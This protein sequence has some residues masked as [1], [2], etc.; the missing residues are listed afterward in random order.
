MKK[1]IILLIVIA[2]TSVKVISQNEKAA[3]FPYLIMTKPSK[4]SHWGY[5][6]MELA[7]WG[8]MDAKGKTIIKPK[9]SYATEFSEGIAIVQLL[10]RKETESSYKVYTKWGVINQKGELII[11]TIFG[12]INAFS[13]GLAKASLPKLSIFHKDYEKL[14]TQIR[15]GYIDSLGDF[16]IPWELDDFKFNMA[17][18]FSEG[19]ARVAPAITLKEAKEIIKDKKLLETFSG[20]F[21]NDENQKVHSSDNPYGFINMK[22]ELVVENKFAYVGDFHEGLAFAKL[23]GDT[24]FGF[25]DKTGNFI[26]Q[27]QYESAGDFSEGLAAVSINSKWGFI[28]KNNEIKIKPI[29]DYAKDFKNGYVAIKIEEKYGFLN[30]KGELIVNGIYDRV[31]EFSN[32]LASV[33][34]KDGYKYQWAF[35]NKKGEEVIPFQF[36]GYEAPKFKNGLA[37]VQI[38]VKESSTDEWNKGELVDVQKFGYLNT[39]GEWIYGP[40]KGPWDAHLN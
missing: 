28:D 38:T 24:L 10:E 33:A 40:I 13:E 17:S 6:D 3:L 2:F 16:V 39:K 18:D 1:L 25:I 21:G 8:Y 7:K 30:R 20:I 31:G 37:L 4:K 36:T 22:G 35:I 32:G 11:D 5:M 19:L 12:R 14:K 9:F 29:Y 23:Y 34:I 27:P 26:I 15:S